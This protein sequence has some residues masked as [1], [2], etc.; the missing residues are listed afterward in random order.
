MAEGKN[1]RRNFCTYNFGIICEKGRK[2][3]LVN[4]KNDGLQY[5]HREPSFLRGK[6][7]EI[8]KEERNVD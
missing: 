4:H 3:H 1:F 6:N 5:G 7:S 8:H 2:L